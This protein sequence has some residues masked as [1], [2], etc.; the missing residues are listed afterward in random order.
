M[1]S[2][3]ATVTLSGGLT[4][5]YAEQGDRSGPVLVLLPGPTDSWLSYEP[6]LEAI[7]PSIRTI[8]VSQRGHGD[9]DKPVTGYRVEDFAADAIACDRRAS[10]V[11]RDT[12]AFVTTST[13]PSI[14][15]ARVQDSRC[16]DRAAL[17]VLRVPVL[18]DPGLGPAPRTLDQLFRMIPNRTSRK[19]SGFS[20]CGACAE[21][22]TTCSGHPWRSAAAFAIVS[23]TIRSWRPQMRWTGPWIRLSSSSGI[24]LVPSDTSRFI[25]FL[26]CL[27]AA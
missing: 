9:S 25:V 20:R 5:S 24:R 13:E 10:H 18:V 11:C 26:T 6:V 23:G 14:G 4:L 27:T 1:R 22:S 17:C 12:V 19:A 3:A 8:A 21:F 7:S 2:V 16:L 15:R